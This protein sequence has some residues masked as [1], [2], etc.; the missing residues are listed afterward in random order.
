MKILKYRTLFKII[1]VGI[2]IFFGIIFQV[3]LINFT[4]NSFTRILN[5]KAK[6]IL[7]KQENYVTLVRL[8]IPSINV[9][10]AIESVGITTNGGVDVPK[11]PF[12]VAW[13][14]QGPFPGEEGNSIVVGHYG[15]KNYKPVV[16][17]NLY[18]LQKGGKIFIEDGDGKITTFV[19]REVKRYSYNED[20]NAVFISS[21]SKAHLNLI[22]CSGAWDE[23]LGTHLSRLVVFAD[24][25]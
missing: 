21:D 14:N 5:G 4:I 16:F 11:D 23:N 2:I 17:N 1:F 3:F 12:N 13:F 10:A 22:T 18:K 6:V 25:E 8:R 20:A 19:V 15:W 24:I 7:T 9:D